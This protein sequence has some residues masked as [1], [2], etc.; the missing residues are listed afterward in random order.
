VPAAGNAQAKL[1]ES[2]R[3]SMLVTLTYEL[4]S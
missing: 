3:L 1:G 4:D 2:L